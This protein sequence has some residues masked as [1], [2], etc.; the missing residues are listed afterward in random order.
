MPTQVVRRLKEAGAV[1][2][3]KLNMHEFAYGDNSIN[4]CFGPVRNPGDRDRIAGGS[5]GGSASAVAVGLCY[6]ALGSDT[7]GSIRQPAAYCGITGLKPT[8]GRVSTRGVIPLS[9]SL[10]HI[11]PMCRSASDAAAFLQAIAG[12]DSLDLTSVNACGRLHPL[13]L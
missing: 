13:A 4:A 1:L 7:G 5:S 8:Y 10:D 6:G 3:S 11:G 2:L 9:W 12:H